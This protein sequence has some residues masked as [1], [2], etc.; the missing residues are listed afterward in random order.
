MKKH[1]I[2]SSCQKYRYALWRIWDEELPI[3]MFIGLN[4]STADAVQD[5]NTIRRCITFAEKW[6]FGGL[7]MGN[8]FALRSVS[9]TA[10]R[11]AKDPIGPENDRWLTT[12]KAKA[13]IAVAVWGDHGTYLGRDKIILKVFPDLYCL[14][15]SMKNIPRHLLY[16]PGDLKPERLKK[17][18]GC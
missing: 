15:L 1:A 14:K 2:I 16:L 12:L 10:L 9:P 5:D 11:R 8:L 13:K 3:V 17:M 7:C 18:L 6:H 4:P